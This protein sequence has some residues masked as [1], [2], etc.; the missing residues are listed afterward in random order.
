[1]K[2]TLITGSCG[3]LGQ[4]FAKLSAQNN[5]NLI[6]IGTNEQRLIN[7][8]NQ[9]LASYNVDIKT[10]VCDQR[11]KE[12][13]EKLKSNVKT[14]EI[15]KAILNAGH[16]D[17]GPF[18]KKTDQTIE[19]VI[20]TN[21]EGTILLSKMLIEKALNNN[22]ELKLLVTSSFSAFYPM[23]NMAIYAASKSMLMNFF[24]ALRYE[25]RNTKIKITTICPSGIYTTQAMKD[26]IK[27]QGLAGKLSSFSPQKIAKLSLKAL[28]K[29][30]AY[31]I[32]GFFNK[33]LKFSSL[34]A[35]KKY[36]TKKLGNRWE[37]SQLNRV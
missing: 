37:K 17:E 31:Y 12:Q 8:K 18:I 16:I 6:L 27:A 23:P 4:E 22:T 25:L 14:I 7:L 30:K 19:S 26:A 2:Y 21:C 11:E 35:S 24:L 3:G 15:S 34:F 20:K 1:M 29:N 32:P 5:E 10:F 9:L 28:N 33:F 36:I 13:R